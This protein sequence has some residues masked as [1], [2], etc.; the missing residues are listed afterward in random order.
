MLD[1]LS[2]THF[3]QPA[4]GQP[5]IRRPNCLKAAPKRAHE[6]DPE[7]SSVEIV[8]GR[9]LIMKEGYL[10]VKNEHN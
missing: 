1:Y 3:R 7:L 4:N 5:S 2:I 8:S 10:P 6:Q 9:P